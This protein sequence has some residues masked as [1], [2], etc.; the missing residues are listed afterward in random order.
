MLLMLWVGRCGEYVKRR[1]C[2]DI[3]ISK[4]KPNKNASRLEAMY[5][6]CGDFVLD[7]G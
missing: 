4:I 2:K 5:I 1:C 7:T 3:V 6:N